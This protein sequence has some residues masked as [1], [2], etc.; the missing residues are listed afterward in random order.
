M[1]KYGVFFGPC[2]PVASWNIGKYGPEKTPYLDTFHAML[3]S[4]PILDYGRKKMKKY[5]SK[6]N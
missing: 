1:C 2:L 3:L 4:S 6:D 5:N